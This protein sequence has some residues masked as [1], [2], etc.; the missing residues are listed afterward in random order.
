MADR[1]ERALWKQQSFYSN[2]H[3][4]LFYWQ[5]SDWLLDKAFVW[6]L[7]LCVEVCDWMS[8]LSLCLPQCAHSWYQRPFWITLPRVLVPWPRTQNKIVWQP[9]PAAFRHSRSH[10]LHFW[11]KRTRL[12]SQTSIDGGA[13]TFPKWISLASLVWFWHWAHRHNKLIFRFN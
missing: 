3:A 12:M 7:F 8:S 11:V 1:V 13:R 10:S 2:I 9:P 5:R 6:R 4:K